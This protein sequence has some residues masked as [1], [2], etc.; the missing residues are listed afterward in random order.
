[1]QRRATAVSVA[2]FLL[3]AAGSFALIGAAQEPDIEVDADHELSN[4]T[5]FEVNGTQYNASVSDGSATIRWTNESQRYTET[6]ANNSNTSY[7]EGT[8]TVRIEPAEDPSGFTLVEAL[9]TTEILRQDSAVNNQLYTDD[10]GTRFVR[11]RSN[12]TLEPLTEYLPAPERVEFSEGGQFPYQNR[13]TTIA[14][15]NN[16]SAVLAWERD[17]EK[18]V[19]PS[20]GANV[21]LS[22]ETFVA[23]Y[24]GDT[25]LLTS[26][27]EA[28]QAEVDAQT[29]FKERTNGLW[30]V[31]I[32]S[33]LTA[34]FLAGLAYLPSRY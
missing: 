12:G 26:D 27:Y 2:V 16:E 19:Q 15:V 8:Y 23:H 13:S 28:Y 30:G 32:L 20:E 31:T 14:A 34:I 5:E 4:G 17:T 10:N 25:L 21:T 22:G 24:E 33:T 6:L 18:S 29:Y 7:Q 9:N 11:Y 3:V 1:M